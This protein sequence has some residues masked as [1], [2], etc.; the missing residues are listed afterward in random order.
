MRAQSK[1]KHLEVMFYIW[2]HLPRRFIVSLCFSTYYAKFNFVLA[3]KPNLLQLQ[4]TPPILQK[5][6]QYCLRQQNNRTYYP[7]STLH[8]RKVLQ[9]YRVLQSITPKTICNPQYYPNK[10]DWKIPRDSGAY[11]VQNSSAVHHDILKIYAEPSHIK[12]SKILL[13]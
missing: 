11:V 1:G 6:F 7:S 10:N 5:I 2:H 9:Y 4:S 3:N 13:V 12:G 8:S